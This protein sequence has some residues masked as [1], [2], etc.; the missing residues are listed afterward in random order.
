MGISSSMTIFIS[1]PMSGHKDFNYPA[2]H[3]AAKLLRAQHQVPFSPAHH[4]ITGEELTPPTAD[5][6]QSWEYYMRRSIRIMLGCE[7][8]YMLHG[9]ETSRGARF[10]HGLAYMLN[11]TIHHQE[12]P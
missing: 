7:A 6:A 11:M 4:D 9:W 2:F 1:G 3:K 5:E 8:V 12:Q 10:E